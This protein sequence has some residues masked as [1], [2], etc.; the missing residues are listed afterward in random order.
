MVGTQYVVFSINDQV[1]G[2]EIF[3][4]KEVLSY[5]TITPLPRSTDFIKGI[6]NLR[7]AIIPVFD[8][9]EKFSLSPQEYSPYHVIM[10]VEI[11][12][13]VMGIIVDE[14]SD[15]VDIYPQELQA[16]EN[17]PPNISKEYLKGVGKK[18]DELIIL[19]DIDHLLSQKEIE[20]A[21]ST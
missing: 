7:G 13:R 6:I 4:I 1:F 3:K 20:L 8:L 11:A 2:I 12:G 16:T 17:L 15:V 21:D 10:V 5:R 19:L 9:R 14:V 18:D